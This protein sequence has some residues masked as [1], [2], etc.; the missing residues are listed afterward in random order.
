MTSNNDNKKARKSAYLLYIPG[1]AMLGVVPMKMLVELERLTGLPSKDLFQAFEGV[2]TG[3]ICVSSILSDY[4]A[5]ETLDRYKDDGQV[6]FDP[7]PNRTAKMA[8]TNVASFVFTGADPLRKH[9]Y[10]LNEIVR[11]SNQLMRAMDES[12][13]QDFD[14]L[15]KFAKQN[16]ISEKHKRSALKIC[17]RLLRDETVSADSHEL[18]KT[19]KIYIDNMDPVGTLTSVFYQ[20]AR[21]PVDFVIKHWAGEHH[22][23]SEKPKETFKEY[24]G[25]KR[26]SDSPKSVYIASYNLEEG[27]FEHFFH[28]KD[29]L[30]SNDANGSGTT[31]NGNEFLWDSTMASI[32][33]P[34]AF[35]PHKTLSDKVYSDQAII[36]SPIAA[37]C[38]LYKHKDADTDIKLVYL[39]VGKFDEAFIMQEHKKLGVVGRVLTG[40]IMT[41]MESYTNSLSRQAL[42]NL[43]GEDNVTLFN[44]R[45]STEEIEKLNLAPS[46]DTLDASPEN[47]AKLEQIAQNYIEIPRVKRRLHNLAI[48]L[49]ENLLLLGQIDQKHLDEVKARCD[50][51]NIESGPHHQDQQNSPWNGVRNFFGWNPQ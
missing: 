43:I 19:M 39:G 27:E 41:D 51:A 5:Q 46:R 31:S 47:T 12:Y 1:G 26:L 4:T 44:P 25:K 22:F 28:R 18:I 50:H 7:I 33:S 6:F 20:A 40:G 35:I 23:S 42:G 48:D 3:S 17:N 24:F 14:N 10:K 16:I 49:C 45:L 2:S 30:L 21:K 9:R 36:H 37:V 29:D 13:Y 11:T 8:F 34:F 15:K 38:D 32:A